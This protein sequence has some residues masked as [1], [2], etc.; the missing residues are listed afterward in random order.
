[1]KVSIPGLNLITAFQPVGPS[2]TGC[3]PV[4]RRHPAEGW[5]PALRP[6]QEMKMDQRLWQR[7]RPRALDILGL[8]DQMQS[9][10]ERARRSDCL[11]FDTAE[12]LAAL[13]DRAHGL[14]LQYLYEV[15]LAEGRKPYLLREGAV[16]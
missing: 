3:P 9:P 10:T 5:F 1:L 6:L 14:V 7:V 8:V 15:G 4:V 12:D 2:C 16:A 13:L 11:D